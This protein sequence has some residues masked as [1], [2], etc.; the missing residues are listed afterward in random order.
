MVAIAAPFIP[1][2]KVNMNIGSRI[3]FEITV[4]R[5]RPI[6]V[7]GLPLARIKLLSPRYKW[8]TTFPSRMYVI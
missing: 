2:P 7:F 3:V 8:V 1:I 6:A 4:K 5:V